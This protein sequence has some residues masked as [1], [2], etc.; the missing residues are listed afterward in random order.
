[1]ADQFD[2]QST[3]Y[4]AI[5]QAARANEGTSVYDSCN[6]QL[7][8]DIIKKLTTEIRNILSSY[9]FI[10]HINDAI[11]ISHIIEDIRKVLLRLDGISYVIYRSGPIK[12]LSDEE[13]NKTFRPFLHI[14]LKLVEFIPYPLR[15]MDCIETLREILDNYQH[16]TKEYRLDYTTKYS[17]QNLLDAQRKYYSDFDR[18]NHGLRQTSPPSEGLKEIS[19]FDKHDLDTLKNDAVTMQILKEGRCLLQFTELPKSV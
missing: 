1:M 3:R 15:M 18:A 14:S 17:L 4:N 2:E 6:E 11:W 13:K 8:K 19:L 12:E 10:H 7:T 9:E 5:W 16:Q